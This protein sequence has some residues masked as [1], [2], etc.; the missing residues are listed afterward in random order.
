MSM[1][2]FFHRVKTIKSYDSLWR[3]N[4]LRQWIYD[5]GHNEAS[6]DFVDVVLSKEDIQSIINQCNKALQDKDT[7]IKTIE[8]EQVKDMFNELLKEWYVLQS[9]E[10]LTMHFSS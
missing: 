5:L 4:F 3:C 2:I 6:I 10:Y 1:D 8:L 9:D 7:S